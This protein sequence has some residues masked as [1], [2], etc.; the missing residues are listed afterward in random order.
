[1]DEHD[2]ADTPRPAER[3]RLSY[4]ATAIANLGLALESICVRVG[5][6]ARHCDGLDG[7]KRRR[8]FLDLAREIRGHGDNCHGVGR[9]IED[10]YR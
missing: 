5:E 2:E 3:R 4:E 10:I 9:I 6:A 1:V 7:D 8:L